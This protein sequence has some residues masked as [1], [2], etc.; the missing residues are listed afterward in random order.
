MDVGSV[1]LIFNLVREAIGAGSKLHDLMERVE[2]GEEIS[3][4]ELSLGDKEQKDLNA[5]LQNLD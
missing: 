4:E 2:N 1:I 5:K 3:L